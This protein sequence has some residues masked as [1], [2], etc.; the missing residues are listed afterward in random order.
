[1]QQYSPTSEHMMLDRLRVADLKDEI[2][3][4]QAELQT[5]VNV[6][7]QTTIK[8]E[9]TTST[10]SLL[11]NSTTITTNEIS[12]LSN[13]AT[14]Q[15]QKPVVINQYVSMQEPSQILKA[16]QEQK[17]FENMKNEQQRF[18]IESVE[19]SRIEQ[20][21]N[22]GNQL[23]TGVVFSS[24]S[25]FNSVDKTKS[26]MLTQS[27]SNKIHQHFGSVSNKTTT[28]FKKELE[29]EFDIESEIRP[30]LIMKKN[31]MISTAPT[32]SSSSTSIL[33]KKS[34]KSK[35]RKEREFSPLS[36]FFNKRANNCKTEV[37]HDPIYDDWF[38]VQKETA[39]KK[40]EPKKQ[41][42]KCIENELSDIFETHASPKTVEKQLDDL[43]SS[44]SKS[45]DLLSASS[46]LTEFFQVDSSQ[47]NEK[48]V[49]NRL[50]A[51]FGEADDE[52][53]KGN[54]QD[55]VETRLE[56]L[57][58]GSV[59]NDNDNSVMENAS[60]LYK[61]N[62]MAY[63]IEDKTAQISNP[64]K[65]HWNGDCDIFGSSNS[66]LFPASPTSKRVCT[67]TSVTFDNKWIEDSFDFT[68]EINMI[69]NESIGT[70]ITKQRTWNGNIDNR[71]SNMID[72]VP[73]T[74]PFNVPNNHTITQNNH[75]N[76]MQNNQTMDLM[77]TQLPNLNFEDP[78]DIS[79]QVQ[80]A[81]DSILNLQSS[82]PLSYS[83][84]DSSFLELNT[85]T[86]AS[87][88]NSIHNHG[89][90]AMSQHDIAEYDMPRN[91]QI[92]NVQNFKHGNLPKRKFST[93][94]DA[95]GDCLI[96]G[97]NLDHSPSSLALTDSQ[98]AESSASVGEFV[99]NLLNCEDKSITS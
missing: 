78:D 88:M 4:L 36:D 5:E 97:T 31:D 58:Q 65:R 32:S 34:T 48:S 96:G 73:T 93:K 50:E 49:E 94:M 84:L 45:N 99:N 69:S 16:K 52:S 76:V 46:P 13:N 35:E 8:K 71:E 40:K 37:A 28:E 17:I 83:Q 11:V 18:K 26:D 74:S 80:N 92:H 53:R 55:L 70:D 24:H 77:D 98:G 86:S 19:T 23:S 15:G 87:S 75:Q 27:N 54:H 30:N 1:M 89:S 68:P 60:F 66:M 38:S 3:S 39:P 64:N 6:N 42:T 7:N 79:R 72:D 44:N 33:D 29:E 51:L 9:I 59:T 67:T 90:N 2:V 10:S 47:M 82:D 91:D 41:Q 43:F 25:K 12:Q 85:I 95:I 57:F 56:Q 21:N 63:E 20:K 14:I 81:I 61:G 22:A 62:N